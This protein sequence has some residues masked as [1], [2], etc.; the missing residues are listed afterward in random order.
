M[1]NGLLLKTREVRVKY[2]YIF[3]SFRSLNFLKN[4]GIQC[5]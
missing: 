1:T 2:N 3:N 5:F 4:K